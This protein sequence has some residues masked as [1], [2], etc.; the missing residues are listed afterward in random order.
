M[1]PAHGTGQLGA[2]RGVDL[3]GSDCPPV[4]H[5]LVSDKSIPALKAKVLA[6]GLSI[7]QLVLNGMGV[8]GREKRGG[9]AA[10]RIRLAPQ[11]DWEVNQP[12]TGESTG[13]ARSHPEHG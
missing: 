11:K 6:S 10:A 9:A 12:A 4:N 8:G 2:E 13:Q 1:G 3:A 5:K 7:G